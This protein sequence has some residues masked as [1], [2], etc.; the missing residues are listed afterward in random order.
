MGEF[1]KDYIVKGWIFKEIKD[2]IWIEKRII[3]CDIE[4]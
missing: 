3:E 4:R 2:R 1:G